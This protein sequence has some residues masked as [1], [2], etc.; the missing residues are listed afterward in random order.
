MIKLAIRVDNRQYKQDQER[1]GAR[2]SYTLQPRS[3]PLKKD[4]KDMI[5]LSKIK[6]GG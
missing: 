5:D 1:K 4:N 2:N 6:V 3:Q